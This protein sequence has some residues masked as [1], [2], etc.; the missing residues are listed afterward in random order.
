[1]DAPARFGQET[2][3][4]VDAPATSKSDWLLA[5]RSAHVKKF[6]AKW[7]WDGWHMDKPLHKEIDF[8]V[9]R[10]APTELSAVQY[11]VRPQQH[12]DLCACA[13]KQ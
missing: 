3:S 7:T 1:M 10:R 4:E 6:G 9:F 2:R 13:Q 5:D 8:V 11:G 12:S